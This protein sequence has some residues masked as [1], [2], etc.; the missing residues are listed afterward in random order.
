MKAARYGAV[1]SSFIIEHF[2]VEEALKI[3]RGQ[4]LECLKSIGG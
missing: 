2:G 4:A 3:T 1:S